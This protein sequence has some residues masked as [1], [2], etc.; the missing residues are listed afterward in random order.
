MG[1]EKLNRR[2]FLVQSFSGLSAIPLLSSS[3]NYRSFGDFSLRTLGKTGIRVTPL[4][5][6]A[7]VAKDVSLIMYAFENGI[8]FID[9]AR[10]Y[11]EGNN[12]ILVGNALTETRDKIV[13]QT[14]IRLDN[15]ELPSNGKGRK[16]SQEIKKTLSSKFNDS[17]RSLNTA[18]IDILMIHDAMDES[19]L[20]HPETIKFFADLKSSGLI[21]ASGFSC[22]SEPGLIKRNNS[23]QFYDVIMTPF[24]K[25]INISDYQCFT[26][27]LSEANE[28]GSGI[29]AMKTNLNPQSDPVKSAKWVLEHRFISSVV[30][31]FRNFTEVDQFIP[32]IKR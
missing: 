32:I 3:F 28:K 1:E 20:F 30:V 19:L 7:S 9:T 15:N 24:H 31:P 16:G 14:K 18:Y 6:G 17:L 8:N 21:R 12:E 27:I 11:S 13:I 22:G 26:D 10:S 2:K 4:C 25:E 5:V 23:E 29:I